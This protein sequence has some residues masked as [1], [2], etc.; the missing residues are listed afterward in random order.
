MT[1]E[2]S[3]FHASN[4]LKGAPK[5]RLIAEQIPRCF[6]SA[7][8]GLR[9]CGNQAWGNTLGGSEHKPLLFSKE[10]F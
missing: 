8:T 5:I 10:E 2:H 9:C 6:P 3:D 7:A 1:T 4:N